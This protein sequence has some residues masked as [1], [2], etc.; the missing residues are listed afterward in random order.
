MMMDKMIYGVA[1]GWFIA[2]LLSIALVLGFAYIIWVLASKESGKVKTTGQVIAIV[3][4][5]L[6]AIMFLYG[7]IYGGLTGKCGPGKYRM[8]HQKGVT[9]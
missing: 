3:V 5:V 6:V 8:M 7:G 2:Y 1:G 9:K 4:A